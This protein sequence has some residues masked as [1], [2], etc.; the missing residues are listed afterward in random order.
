M[1]KYLI[2]ITVLFSSIHIYPQFYIKGYVYDSLTGNPLPDVRVNILNSNNF[3]NTSID[4]FFS[5]EVPSRKEYILK[6]SLLGYKSVT[7][8]LKPDSEIINVFIKEQTLALSEIDVTAKREFG[9]LIFNI[10]DAK[11]RPVNTSQDLLR[12][13]PGL[14]IAQHAGGGKAEQIFLR[15][16]DCDHGTDLYISVD[17]MPVNMVSHA[18]GQGYADLHFVIPETIENINVFKGPYNLKFGDFSTAGAVEFLTKN[19]INN[20]SVKIEYGKFNSSRVAAL[21]NILPKNLLKHNL[22]FAGEY[23]F[24]DGYFELKQ[25]FSRYN[26][27]A[28]YFGYPAKSMTAELSISDFNAH[29]NASGQIPQRTVDENIISRFGSIDSS[30]GGNTRRS[31]INLIL[32]NQLSN[33]LNIKNQLFYVYY[34]FNLVSNF[35]F[36]LNDTVKGDEISQFDN[37]H[38]FGYQST[39]K[40]KNN[41]KYL[42]SVTALG[43]G[44]R[45]D[46]SDLYLAKSKHRI[47]YNF[48]SNGILNQKNFYVYAEQ[49]IDF[50]NSFSII[51]G[52]RADYFIFN[53]KD[54]LEDINFSNLNFI[55]SPKLKLFYDFTKN[56]QLYLKTGYGFHSNDARTLVFYQ[57]ENT[58]PKA[59]GYEI[60]SQFKIGK[61]FIGNISFWGLNLESEFIYVGDE[62]VIEPSGRSRRLGAEL[63][64]RIQ[65]NKW[66]WADADINYTYAR[67]IDEPSGNNFIPLAPDLSSFGGVTFKLPFGFEGSIRYRYLKNRPANESNS[68]VAKGHFINDIL[69]NY[70]YKFINFGVNFENIF[71]K[72][73]NEAQ[74]D[75]ESRLL[76]ETEPVSELHFTPGTPFNIKAYINL[77]F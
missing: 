37:R 30:E 51:G 16:F 42:N 50:L 33:N 21:F 64:A 20:N 71:N 31:N 34:K 49:Q 76:N 67:L 73:W 47:V 68:V 17:G 43:T 19:Q 55:V 70:S 46:L 29:W 15:G 58:L 14:F 32:F 3:V 65:F 75:T 23:A 53:Y 40:I 6:F 69:L 60:G 59:F 9:A 13:V 22:Y 61:N 8:T 41:F 52:L 57:K 10:L 1:I 48:L 7:E 2:I 28:K 5:V 38:I 12:L 4:G 56:L 11:L 44:F 62:A 27:F 72:K 39:L 74:F 77:N 63:S 26:L 36:F 35:T 54:K 25:K 18:H 66:L 24:T 45:F